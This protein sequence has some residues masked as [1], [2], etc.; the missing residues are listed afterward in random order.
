ML[1]PDRVLL[2]DGQIEMQ[3]TPQGL[4][5]FFGC[6]RAE[7]KARRI[8]GEKAHQSEGNE[9]DQKDLRYKEQDPS[10]YIAR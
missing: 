6:K 8:A 10:S 4:D 1:Q 7:L 2:R 5:G 9:G 3:L